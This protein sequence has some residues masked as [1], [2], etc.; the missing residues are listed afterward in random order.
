MRPILARCALVLSAAVLPAHGA[1]CPVETADASTA[2]VQAA[3]AAWNDA[4]RRKDLEKTMAIFSQ[5]IRFQV[6]G[7]PDFGY[8][9]LLANYTASY[10]RENAPQW[11]GFVESVIGSPEMVTLL[12]EWKLMPVGGGDAI[13]EYRGA[14]IFQRESDC[15]WRI[16]VSLNYVDASTIAQSPE[17]HSP[18]PATV[19]SDTVH[20]RIAGRERVARDL[21][22]VFRFH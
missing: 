16:V 10:A 17:G 15:A 6:Q 22:F 13:R 8:P 9:R 3:F 5:S 11:Q 21:D 12:S 1:T 20:P 19:R 7:S 4:V 14:D 2:Q 18:G